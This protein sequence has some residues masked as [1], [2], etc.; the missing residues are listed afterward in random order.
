MQKFCGISVLFIGADVELL[1]DADHTLKGVFFQDQ[2][3]KSVY[4][5]F[6]E[7]VCMDATYKLLETKFPVFILLCEDSAGNTIIFVYIIT[8][9]SVGT[10]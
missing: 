2:H 7:F 9:I 1:T 3:M 4:E 8:H 5:A 10:Q 6:P